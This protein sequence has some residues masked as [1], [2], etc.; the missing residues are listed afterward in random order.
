[1]KSIKLSYGDK[2]LT[3]LLITVVGSKLHQLDTKN[4]DIDTKGVFVWDL[5]ETL[6][7]N[8]PQDTLENKNTDSKLWSDLLVDLN[9]NLGL[10]IDVLADF[11]LFEIKK[12]MLLSLKNDFNM[13]DML[14]SKPV[15]VNDSFKVVM[16]NRHCFLNTDSAKTRFVGMSFSALKEGKKTGDCKT[17]SRAIQFLHSVLLVFK[18]STY[19]PVLLDK[20]RKEVLSIKNCEVSLEEIKNRFEELKNEVDLCYKNNTKLTANKELINTMLV[21]IQKG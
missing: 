3:L 19:S 13:F 4:S 16:D 1:M 8:T 5:N 18:T 9:R 15:Y 17:L 2:K 11:C 21:R 12:F 20:E 7:L 6:S 10:H 14:W